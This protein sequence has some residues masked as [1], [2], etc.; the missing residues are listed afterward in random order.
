[1]IQSPIGTNHLDPTTPVE[2]FEWSLNG[3]MY[4]AQVPGIGYTD[5]GTGSFSEPNGVG[6]LPLI[7]NLGGLGFKETITAN[8][9]YRTI[10]ITFQFQDCGKGCNWLGGLVRVAQPVLDG[11]V[12]ANFAP[13]AYAGIA[14]GQHGLMIQE[15][16]DYMDI[17]CVAS[18]SVPPDA[19]NRCG[20]TPFTGVGYIG[21][22]A[23]IQTGSHHTV[24]LRQV[25][26]LF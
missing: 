19:Y 5:A 21:Q 22:E 14:Y 2:G 1:M 13:S 8:P 16:S 15:L 6:K 12:T 18:G 26:Q 10:T 3:T 23:E 11:Q 17:G 25:Y 9:T 7:A 4:G 24:T 20:A